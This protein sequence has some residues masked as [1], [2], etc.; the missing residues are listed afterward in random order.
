MDTMTDQMILEVGNGEIMIFEE[1]VL[2]SGLCDFT[3]PVSVMSMGGK[4]QII[5]HID[6]YISVA[7]MEFDKVSKVFEIVEKTIWA[8]GRSRE[9]LID[10]GKITLTCETVFYNRRKKDVKIAY[11]PVP[12][13]KYRVNDSISSFMGEL[14]ERTSGESKR[15]L[16]TAREKIQ[17]EGL[18]LD[19]ALDYIKEVRRELIL[20]R[21]G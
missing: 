11:I 12:R 5:Y 17:G 20:H 8:L 16:M 7:S 10:P 21:V 9:F 3:V 15:Y 1:R 14:A 2:M 13:P 18:S 4:K 6:G 19:D